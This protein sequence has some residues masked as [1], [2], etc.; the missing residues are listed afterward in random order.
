M[1]LPI[2]KPS[3]VSYAD[4]IDFNQLVGELSKNKH[5]GFIRVTHGSE[6]GYLLFKEGE[7]IA[8]SYDTYSKLD[9]LEKIRSVTEN[10]RTLVEVFDI[11]KSQIDFLL[12]LNKHYI[13][14]LKSETDDLLSELQTSRGYKEV[15][16]N[17]ETTAL[18]LDEP[19]ELDE[20]KTEAVETIEEPEIQFPNTESPDKSPDTN[21]ISVTDTGVSEVESVPEETSA[22]LD[23]TAD[24]EPSTSDALNTNSL[25]T[26][27]IEDDVDELEPETEV[28]ET[29]SQSEEV[30]E[31]EVPLDRLDLLKKYGIKEVKE[32]DVENLLDTY[33]G[34]SVDEGDVEKIE[35]T[36][37]NKIKKSVL[38]LPKIRGAEVMV[39][40]DNTNGLS[41][42]VN[43]IIESESQGFLSKLRGDSKDADNLKRQIINISQIEIRKSFRK[44]PEIVDEF[45]V[46]VEM[47]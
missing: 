43:I 44:Y 27:T 7:Q 22:T 8:A 32:E 46:N 4:Q 17:K 10:D 28:S 2:T 16:E 39:F 6:D 21:E 26:K 47:N 1:E 40:L 45:D 13:I 9:A 33:K 23:G 20:L 31:P 25:D 18:K 42:H 34:G 5:N 35:L 15:E 12:D 14:N 37:M 29:A 30:S 11:K 3:M 38:G 36:L 41:G 19:P 24:S